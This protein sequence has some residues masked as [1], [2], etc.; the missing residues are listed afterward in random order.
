MRVDKKFNYRA[1]FFKIMLYY[2]ILAILSKN[3]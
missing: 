1:N 2:A 3:K